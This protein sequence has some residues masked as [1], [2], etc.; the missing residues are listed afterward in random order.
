MVHKVS[1]ME[2]DRPLSRADNKLVDWRPRDL[3]NLQ[4]NTPP[5]MEE[6]YYN[7][8]VCNE[9]VWHR[10]HINEDSLKRPSLDSDVSWCEM[11]MT[12]HTD[13]LQFY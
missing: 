12:S 11:M 1:I 4:K 9:Q 5:K 7:H 13:V 6:W 2:I 10:T 8:V 3:E